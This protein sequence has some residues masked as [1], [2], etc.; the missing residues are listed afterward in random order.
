MSLLVLKEGTMQFAQ[1]RG[2]ASRLIGETARPD[3]NL[4]IAPRTGRSRCLPEGVV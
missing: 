4:I 2:S 3:A 1:R